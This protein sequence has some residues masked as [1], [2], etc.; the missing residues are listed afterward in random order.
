MIALTFAL[1]AASFR[2]V[3]VSGE[4]AFQGY[5]DG[6]TETTITTTVPTTSTLSDCSTTP[7][8]P[9]PLPGAT[10]S[11]PVEEETFCTTL[12][13]CNGLSKACRPESTSL[14]TRTIT[15]T[16]T[17][18]STP[19][20]PKPSSEVAS[21]PK[22]SIT[23]ST[24]EINTSTSLVSW[25]T[26]TTKIIA[27]TATQTIYQNTTTT[28][29]SSST[30]TRTLYSNTT[31]TLSTLNS[32]TTIHSFSTLTK[33]I[34]FNTTEP[35][36]SPYTLTKTLNNNTKA[37][38]VSRSTIT[39][40]VA[41]NTTQITTAI[42]TIT[43]NIDSTTGP[44]T[45]TS[46][47]STNTP[48]STPPNG[49]PT[50]PSTPETTSAFPPPSTPPPSCTGQCKIAAATINL[51][52]WPDQTA[53]TRQ[54]V[55][56]SPITSVTAGL[57]LTHPTVYFSLQ[58]L[59][60]YETCGSGTRTVDPETTLP[61]FFPFDPTDI[62]TITWTSW[63]STFTKIESGTTLQWWTASWSTVTR[64]FDF[65][66]L[67]SCSQGTY[68]YSFPAISVTS[69]A[70]GTYFTGASTGIS[71][72]SLAPC[73]PIFALPT[74]ITK[75]VPAWSTC[76]PNAPNGWFDPTITWTPLDG[77]ITG[78]YGSATTAT[79]TAVPAL[80]TETATIKTTSQESASSSSPPKTT[81]R[82]S[83]TFSRSTASGTSVVS[84]RSS[85]VS[86]PRSSG[87]AEST[88][89]KSKTSSTKRS[90]TS[91]SGSSESSPR[92]VLAELHGASEP[93]GQNDLLSLRSF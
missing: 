44:S 28:V 47:S 72:V 64:S 81:P 48:A 12:T 70:S 41:L 83:G 13:H 37:T 60:A 33:S 54:V 3:C 57:T 26:T 31:T 69:A 52:V 30:T 9:P 45:L 1:L 2:F 4:E 22:D 61:T 75:F 24:A 50:T 6:Y 73:S 78:P 59:S 74:K 55:S 92:T 5:T 34:D 19:T 46:S 14:S 62:S 25:N 17:F 67:A 85:P 82:S 89:T 56:G 10:F 49:P 8:S 84:S 77:E 86:I 27:P 63:S 51:I 65:A 23:Q 39:Q 80:D 35:S 90:P 76:T 68:G 20:Y 88:T 79:A 21:M 43:E 11:I 91:T 93:D 71:P 32:M 38:V 58:S 18:T 40:T 16:K 36:L 15:R 29:T 66:Q 53:E 87:T 42:S 7:S